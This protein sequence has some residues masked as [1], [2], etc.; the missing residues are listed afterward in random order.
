MENKTEYWEAQ[1]TVSVSRE[2]GLLLP[3]VRFQATTSTPA[4]SSG[5]CHRLLDTA[6]Y[7]PWRQ[8]PKPTNYSSILRNRV[9]FANALTD[10]NQPRPQHAFK[11]PEYQ[12]RPGTGHT[13]TIRNSQA[14]STNTQDSGFMRA[15]IHLGIFTI[16]GQS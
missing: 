10:T 8:R 5:L 4:L 7:S 12:P 14:T 16:F 11:G 6:G 9:C 1:K 13:T 2:N 15:K 3:S